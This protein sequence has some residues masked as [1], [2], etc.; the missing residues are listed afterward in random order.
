MSCA[1]V[2]FSND[3]PIEPG[4]VA[5]VRFPNDQHPSPAVAKVH[6]VRFDKVL[7]SKHLG[8]R[9]HKRWAKARWVP[10]VDIAREATAREEQVG[11][12]IDPLPPRVT[13]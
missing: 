7:V 6:A 2:R 10:K 1:I 3:N 5:V 8:P 9:R 13:G 12:V 4:R 11:A